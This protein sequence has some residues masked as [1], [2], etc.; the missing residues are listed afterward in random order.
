MAIN[1]VV[2]GGNTLID[3]TDTTAT[4]E[5]VASGKYFYTNAG[6]KTAGTGTGGGGASVTQDANG[7]IVLPSTGG[8]GGGGATQHTIHL[9]FSDSS[10]TDVDV[11]YDDSLIGTMITA[12]NP[13]T[14]TYS[15]KTVTLAQ[16]DG[17][18]WYNK[19]SIPIGVEL[20]DFNACTQ[21]TAINSAGQ[22]V[23]EQWYWTSDYTAV[24]PTM[25]FTYRANTWFY[26]GLYDSSYNVVDT[27]SVYNDGTQDPNVS[28]TSYGTL[29]GNKLT[30]ASY[31]KLCGSWN[32]SD[33]MSLIRTA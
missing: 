30:G 21:D 11:Y 6:V 19:Q 26:I 23:S 24:D 32:D 22:V 14:W 16:L 7:Y 25:T 10:D 12:Y 29:S 18:T 33:N 4:A 20:I 2:Y 5:D 31:V 15:T 28:N 13:A 8:G 1:K 9:E 17:T 27:I 3:I